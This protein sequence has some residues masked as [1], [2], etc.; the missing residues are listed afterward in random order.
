LEALKRVRKRKNL[1]LSMEATV[2]GDKTVTNGLEEG[3]FGAN[4][5]IYIG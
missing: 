2:S 4:E 1:N 3:G 5:K